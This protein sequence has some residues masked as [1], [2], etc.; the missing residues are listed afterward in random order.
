VTAQTKKAP[1]AMTVAPARRRTGTGKVNN[2]RSKPS[3][4]LLP[5]RGMPMVLHAPTKPRNLKSIGKSVRS[6]TR[7]KSS[8]IDPLKTN[9]TINPFRFT[10][11]VATRCIRAGHNT[12]KKPPIIQ[13]MPTSAVA[14][15]TMIYFLRSVF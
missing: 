7:N 15:I 11:L 9:R 8:V 4:L 14:I 12:R 5:I 3:T 6:A 10:L 1:P 13:A 2:Q